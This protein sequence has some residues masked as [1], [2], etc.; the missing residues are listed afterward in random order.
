[1]EENIL[2]ESGK[3]GTLL[4]GLSSPLKGMNGSTFL[5]GG[6]IVTPTGTD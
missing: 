2:L 5:L 4:K 3:L 1:M 6:G